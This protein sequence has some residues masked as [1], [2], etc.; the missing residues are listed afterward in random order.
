MLLINCH[1]KTPSAIHNMPL[2]KF[3]E[4]NFTQDELIEMTNRMLEK[5]E[6]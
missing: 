2:W 3:E 6:N 5:Y 1:T 4:E